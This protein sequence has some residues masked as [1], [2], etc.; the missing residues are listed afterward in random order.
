V[1]PHHAEAQ[2]E[3]KAGRAAK[4]AEDIPQFIRQLFQGR[5]K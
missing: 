5:N 2:S 1:S 3:R 4:A